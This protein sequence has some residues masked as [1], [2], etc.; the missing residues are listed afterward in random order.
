M[1]SYTLSHSENTDFRKARLFISS[2]AFT[3]LLYVRANGD[4]DL[5]LII[6][7]ERNGIRKSVKRIC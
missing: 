7:S 5:T 4:K 6:F 3:V 1:I 2:K